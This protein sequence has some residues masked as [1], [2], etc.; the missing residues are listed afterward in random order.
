MKYLVD[1]CPL[2]LVSD[3]N[4]DY[5]VLTSSNLLLGYKSCDN[6]IRNGIQIDQIDFGYKNGNKKKTWL[7]CTEADALKGTYPT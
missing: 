4:N 2:L 5:D 7:I 1:N 3:Y 6:N